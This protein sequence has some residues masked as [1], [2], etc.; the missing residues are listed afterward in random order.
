MV[1]AHSAFRY[2]TDATYVS[3]LAPFLRDGLA[4][5][6]LV[7]VAAPPARADLLRDALGADAAGVRFLPADEWYDRPMHAIAAWA[8]LLRRSAARG[9]P[10]ARI[11]GHTPWTGPVAGWGRYEAA[12]NRSLAGFDSHLLCAYDVRTTPAAVLGTVDRTHP[13]VLDRGWRESTTFG[14]EAV[15]AELADP[16]WPVT[17]EPVLT[18]PVTEMV[19]ELRTLVRE[20]CRAGAWLPPARAESLVLALSELA[21]NGVRHGGPRRELR[22][23][24]LPDAVVGEVSDDGPVA[25]EP[26]CGYLPPA[27]GV[28]GGMGLWLI[29]QLCDGLTL[30]RRDGITRARFVL[31]REPGATATPA[32]RASAADHVPSR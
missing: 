24:V 23:W 16:P 4:R 22:I 7:A 32:P 19:A 2:E 9:G 11:V 15:L 13:R 12:L 30:D 3:A 18:L 29:H 1:F 26:I 28:S 10:A 21:T 5:E 6:Q 14:P 20:R 31:L 17:G 25:P 27:P 8:R